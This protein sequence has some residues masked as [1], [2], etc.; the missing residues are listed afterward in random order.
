MHNDS[1]SITKEMNQLLEAVNKY[2]NKTLDELAE[3]LQIP[4][5]KTELLMFQLMS[6]DLVS[7]LTSLITLI[8]LTSEGKRVLKAGLP[9]NLLLT[10]LQNQK[11]IALANV[12]T[13]TGLPKQAVNAAIGQLRKEKIITIEKGQVT[14]TKATQRINETLEEALQVI[15]DN[16]SNEIQ[17]QILNHLLRRKLV[18]TKDRQKTIVE[19][20]PLGVKS[21]P[22]LKIVQTVSKL[23]PDQIR[24]GE[25]RSLQLKKYKIATRPKHIPIGRKHPYL[26][27]LQEVKE[28][29]LGLGFSEMRGPIVETEFWN[30]D[31]LFAAQDHPA[32]E[33]TDV[34]SIQDPPYG[35]LPKDRK[36]VNA[37][38]TVHETGEPVGSRGWRYNWSPKKASLLL[39]RPQ[40]TSVSARTL[41]NLEIP[42]KFFSIARCY[43]PDSVDATHLSEFNQLEGIVCDPSITFRDLLGIL[44]TFAVEVAEATKVKFRPDYYPFTSPSVELSALHPKLGYIEFGGAGMFRPEVTA[45]FEIKDPVIAW[46]IGVDR[47]YMVKRGINDIRELFTQKL[48]W[49]RTVP[50]I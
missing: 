18:E 10:F 49:L 44:K 21:L 4:R 35:K 12:A 2:K 48:E 17:E 27:F 50:V 14:L 42:A 7:R 30:F 13:A 40:G 29:L 24:T 5:A 46:G 8:E 28:K 34:Y 22:K 16:A 43:R 9:E 23:T 31:A 47:L 45:P 11:K 26:L 32:R 25:W 36:L 3:I 19:I 38:K 20:T 1:L 39:L 37:V 15:A 6:K 41:Y 33:P